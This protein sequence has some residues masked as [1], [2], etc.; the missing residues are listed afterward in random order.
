M[1]AKRCDNACMQTLIDEK[2]LGC[3]LTVKETKEIQ[4]GPHVTDRVETEKDVYPRCT[5]RR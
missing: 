2:I 4:R 5:S 1:K 3:M